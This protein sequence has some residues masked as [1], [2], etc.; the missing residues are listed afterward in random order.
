M[1]ND[2]NKKE[3]YIEIPEEDIEILGKDGIYRKYGVYKKYQNKNNI[4]LRYWIPF[5]LAII[6]TFSPIDLIPDRIPL[7]KLDD[8][9]LLIITF[10]YGIKKANFSYNTIINIIIRN[11]ILSITITGFVMMIVIYILAVLL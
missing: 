6:Y 2:K 1:T 9:L 3:D 4:K 10:I 11:I 5:V 7:G 8:I